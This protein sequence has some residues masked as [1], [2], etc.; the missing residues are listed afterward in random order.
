MKSNVSSTEKFRGFSK[1]KRDEKDGAF[2]RSKNKDGKRRDGNSGSGILRHDFLLVMKQS[3]GLLLLGLIVFTVLFPVSTCAVPDTSIFNVDYTHQQLK[4]RFCADEVLPLI[5]AASVIFGAACGMR[6]FGFLTD[7]NRTSFYMSLGL[8]RKKL[9][10]NRL[11]AGFAVI[12]VSIALP[13]LA[14]AAL[15]CSA[16]GRYD[17]L[18]SYAAYIGA[19]LTVQA[20]CALLIAAAACC[21]AG[22]FSEAA[23]LGVT[24]ATAPS[25]FFYFINA[26]MKT[27]LWGNVFG[28]TTYAMEN[29]AP[30]L[31]EKLS[32]AN[33]LIFFYNELKTH[34]FY[35]R[36]MASADPEPVGLLP[37]LPQIAVILAAA[38]AVGWLFQRRKSENAGISGLSRFYGIFLPAVWSLGAF[39]L[40]LDGMRDVNRRIAAVA[41]YFCFLL[42]FFVL[43]A[44]SGRGIQIR[45]KL[46]QCA[47]LTCILAAGI[48]LTDTGMLGAG[49]KIPETGEISSVS[50][51]YVG[52]PALMPSQVQ[53][54]SSGAA[55]YCSGQIILSEEESVAQAKELHQKLSEGGIHDLGSSDGDFSGTVVPYDIQVDYTLKSGRR[56]S[57]YYDRIRLRELASFLT[58]ENCA[59]FRSSS[60]AVVR[61]EL[62]STLWN[63]EAFAAGEIYLAD[64]WLGE[65]RRIDPGE[66]SRRALLTAIAS[67]LSSQSVSD[68]YFPEEDAGARLFFTLNGESDLDTF[69]YSTSNVSVWI[70]EDFEETV[71]LLK[72]WGAEI[73]FDGA[74]TSEADTQVSADSKSQKIE[75]ITLQKFDP[76]GSMNCISDPVSVLFQSYKSDS[77]D[78]FPFRQDFGTRPE[79]TEAEQISEIAPALRSTYFMSGGGYIAAVKLTGGSEY[80]Y[81]FLPYESA[82]DFIRQK[83]K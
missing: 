76:Y 49:S 37:L 47:C 2:S 77:A 28:E 71:A 5:Q 4:F 17:G 78:E 16:L 45:R 72:G 44:V 34:Y 52:Q 39:A 74:G 33:P 3:R 20:F 26:L 54:S 40:I 8:K 79:F 35:S 58:L 66:E 43:S 56:I 18:L 23:A 10:G 27:Y 81:K 30:G 64:P 48:L 70:T 62:A 42:V 80:I 75:S 31:I 55:Y 61:G 1:K 22:T 9:Y 82:P 36:E 57:R 14:S 24:A 60:S 53:A 67:D 11:A 50:I 59:E 32:P 38:A 65:I 46:I 63:Y 51:S 25:I 83:M 12:A 6:L 21:I 13:V 19:G 29:V 73:Y 41:A 68:R 7:R 69:A 15:N